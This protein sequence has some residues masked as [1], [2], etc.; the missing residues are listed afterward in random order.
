[1]ESHTRASIENTIHENGL[2]QCGLKGRWLS[3]PFDNDE[4]N[5]HWIRQRVVLLRRVFEQH[6]SHEAALFCILHCQF[7]EEEQ[8]FLF[9]QVRDDLDAASFELTGLYREPD[10]SD[11]DYESEWWRALEPMREIWEP[12]ARKLISDC[13]DLGVTDWAH[14][15]Y[16]SECTLDAL[17]SR[18]KPPDVNKQSFA[19][20]CSLVEDYLEYRKRAKTSMEPYSG[21]F[22]SL[23]RKRADDLVR[24]VDLLESQNRDTQLAML[25]RIQD[26]FPNRRKTND[27]MRRLNAVGEPFELAFDDLVTRSHVDVKDYRGKIVLIDFWA[28]W[29][30]PCVDFLSELKRFLSDHEREVVLIGISCDRS[31]DTRALEKHVAACIRKHDINWPIVIDR[32]IHQEWA[33]RMIPTLFAVDRNGLLRSTKAR[34]N[35]PEIPEKLLRES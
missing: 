11:E 21:Y 33:V 2:L 7:L 19:R 10:W 24:A 34:E 18:D 12:R 27:L 1:M 22:R 23:L 25:Q 26:L 35:F 15:H 16:W 29:C 6:P 8:P 28:T 13:P 17:G 32:R 20:M 9:A 3:P 4:A 5:E 31:A 30:Q 14:N